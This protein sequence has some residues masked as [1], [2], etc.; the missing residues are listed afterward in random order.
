MDGQRVAVDTSD[1]VDKTFGVNEQHCIANMPYEIR[2]NL[3]KGIV[4][5][6]HGP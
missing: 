6:D 2:E 5:G 3:G 1:L 4:H